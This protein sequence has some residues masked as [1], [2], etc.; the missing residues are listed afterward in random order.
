M[1][2]H[3]RWQAVELRIPDGFWG[4]FEN[5]WCFTH[6]AVKEPEALPYCLREQRIEFRSTVH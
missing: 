4:N 3:I 5:P 1:R 6:D 2:S